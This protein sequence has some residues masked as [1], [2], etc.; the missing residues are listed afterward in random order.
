MLRT[1]SRLTGMMDFC[2][3]EHLNPIQATP[4]QTQCPAHGS[5]GKAAGDVF[6]VWVI[7]THIAD[8]G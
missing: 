2:M 4:P 5:P 7:D 6:S 8:P 3:W 1:G